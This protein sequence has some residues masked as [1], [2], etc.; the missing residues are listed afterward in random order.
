MD[1]TE[2]PFY[3]SKEQE[4]NVRAMVSRMSDREKIGQLFVVLGDAYSAQ[5]LETL[6]SEKYIGG[7]LFRPDETERVKK[8]Y[9][10]LQKMAK[11]PLLRAANLEEGGAGVLT[12]GTYFLKCRWQQRMIRRSQKSSQP[13]ARRRE[14]PSA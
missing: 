9:E 12:D 14:K 13:C 6:V 8:K 10:H 1:L 7:V 11:Y 2:K 5:E 3:L 4:E